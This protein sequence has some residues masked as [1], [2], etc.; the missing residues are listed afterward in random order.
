MACWEIM[1]PGLEE[2]GIRMLLNE[3]EIIERSDQCIY[4]AGVDDAHFY[5]A[6]NSRKLLRE[7]RVTSFQFYFRTRQK[8]IGRLPLPTSIFS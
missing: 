2:I 8:Y 5:R 6:D 4:L 1:T 3:H 7:Y